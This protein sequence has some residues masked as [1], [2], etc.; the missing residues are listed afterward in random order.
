MNKLASLRDVSAWKFISLGT[1]VAF[2]FLVYPTPYELIRERNSISR[3]N[4]FTGVKEF[5]TNSGWKTTKQLKDESEEK[6]KALRGVI[7]EAFSQVKF[8]DDREDEEKIAVS[9]PTSWEFNAVGKSLS[10]EYLI[11][12]EDG[13]L[14]F[15]A[16]GRGD[17]SIDANGHS[18]IT[19]STYDVRD[20]L[21]QIPPGTA[22]R[23]KITLTIDRATN[24]GGFPDASYVTISP[25]LTLTITRD[26][27]TDYKGSKVL[28][29][30]VKYVVKESQTGKR[31]KLRFDGEP[32]DEEI[33]AAADLE[34]SKNAKKQ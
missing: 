7:A 4:R 26:F 9:N 6:D 28:G 33:A 12:K 8:D 20:S 23:Q 14:Q 11:I 2:F 27:T 31:L 22:Y 34:F 3:V 18:D 30:R 19:L 24:K 17:S 15:V 21:N 16:K 13:T 5:S 10:V 32:T 29:K 1:I 25:P